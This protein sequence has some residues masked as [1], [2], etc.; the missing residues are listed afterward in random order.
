MVPDVAPG[1]DARHAAL[2]DLQILDRV[3][4]ARALGHQ[5]LVP[6]EDA[7]ADRGGHREQR[8]RHLPETHS[9][10][11]QRDELV[12]SGEKAE[13]HERPGEHGKRCHLGHH[14]GQ[15]EEEVADH[16]AGRRFVAEKAVEPIEEVD[17]DVDRHERDEREGEDAQ[18]LPGHV[19][20]D[21]RCEEAPAS[22]HG[23]ASAPRRATSFC[24][25]AA[26]PICM[27]SNAAADRSRAAW[28]K[29]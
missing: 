10:G 11:A 27:R 1:E 9:A 24:R 12:V 18:E 16:R 26:N 25:S 21:D 6:D 15:F 8:R 2:L 5:C 20:G 19:S 22:A 13:A 17:D 23:Q 28:A 29:R 3:P 4:A 7:D 14:E